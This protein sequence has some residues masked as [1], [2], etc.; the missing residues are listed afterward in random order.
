[1]SEKLYRIKNLKIYFWGEFNELGSTDRHVNW[2]CMALHHRN[3]FDILSKMNTCNLCS[4]SQQCLSPVLKTEVKKCEVLI[5]CDQPDSKADFEGEP[6]SGPLGNLLRSCIQKANLHTDEFNVVYAVKC[7]LHGR[8]QT[9]PLVSIEACR[10]Y[11]KEEIDRCRPRYILCLGDVALRSVTK[12]SGVRNNRG[13]ELQT[14]PELNTDAKVFCTY[15]IEYLAQNSNLE[16]TVVSDMRRCV[17]QSTDTNVPWKMWEGEKIDGHLLAYDIEAI[18]EDGEFTDYPTQ[19]AVANEEM[20][21]VSRD[22]SNLGGTLVGRNNVGHNAF[23]Y[24]GPMLRKF[25]LGV[26]DHHDTMY[27]AFFMDETQPRGL[28][29]LA[30]KYLGVPGWKEAFNAKLGSEEFYFYNARDTW[31][32]MQLFL[33]F[34][35]EL[36]KDKRYYLIENLIHPTRR[37]LDDMSSRGVCLDSAYILDTKK[38]V[39]LALAEKEL[40]V[41]RM[42]QTLIHDIDQK[43]INP[44]STLQIAQCLNTLHCVLPTTDKGHP[45]TSKDVL[46]DYKHIPFVKNL[47]EYREQA[48]VLSTYVKPYEKLSQEGD[49]K[50]HPEYKMVSVETGRTSATK[51][52]VQNLD[53]EL[54]GFFCAPKGKVLVSVDYNAIEFR[55]ASRLAGERSILSRFKENPSWDPHMYFAGVFFKNEAIKSV[56]LWAMLCGLPTNWVGAKILSSLF[57]CIREEDEAREILEHVQREGWDG[58]WKLS[59]LTGKRTPLLQRWDK[60]VQAFSEEEL[61]E[62][63]NFGNLYEVKQSQIQARYF[64]ESACSSQ[65]PQSEKQHGFKSSDALSALS[66]NTSPIRYTE[67]NLWGY[68]RQIAKSC[69]FSQ[70]YCGNGFTL[71]EY[72]KK[73]GVELNLYLCEKVHEE[74]HNTFPGFERYYNE[75]KSEI[76]QTGQIACPT[77]FVRHFGD[78]ELIRQNY[79]HKFFGKLRQAVNVPVQNLAAHIAFLAMKRLQELKFPMVLFVHDSISFELDDDENLEGKIKEIEQVMCHYPV[80]ALKDEY[81]VILEVPLMVESTVK[82]NGP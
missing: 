57:S 58:E 76:L 21:F 39:S 37:I 75:R 50:A 29:A 52:N 30:V 24:D 17:K 14:I 32:T 13:S 15:S 66:S 74:W 41:R 81:N 3:A 78:P 2:L 45:V 36:S 72:A 34:R 8:G 77:G 42:M 7:A 79:G 12:R 28:E 16:R 53:R 80:K 54:K 43:K 67:K 59:S 44:N 11:L 26:T 47:L 49:G 22:V 10:S 40:T 56:D 73:Q 63:R 61:R 18:D 46:Q 69:N 25:G 20:C 1:M 19:I 55:I 9:L 71:Y 6:F 60:C 5:V 68:N 64:I 70:I 4:L 51:P 48:K 62:L 65:R 27:M 38:R 31:Y 33:L 35:K 82:R 23:H